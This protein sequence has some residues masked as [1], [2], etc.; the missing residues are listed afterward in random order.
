MQKYRIY[1]NT[2]EEVE[3]LKQAFLN[4]TGPQYIED[5]N[6]GFKESLPLV[7]TSPL[8]VVSVGVVNPLHKDGRANRRE[9]RKK[10]RK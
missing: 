7:I 1:P 2:P 8:P 3:E 6:K 5:I 10:S 4:P 9:R